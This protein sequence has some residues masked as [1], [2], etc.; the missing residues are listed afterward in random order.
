[1]EL[2]LNKNRPLV[3]H[4]DLN[5]CFATAAQQAFVHLRGKPLVV[6]AYA[7]PNGCVLSPSVEAKTYGIKTGMTVREAK[8]LCHHVQVRTP[9][10]PLV[11]DIH[12]KFK[13]IFSDY[14]PSVIPK[15]IDEAV[16]D[17]TP[18]QNILK[19]DLLEIG[20]EIKIRL[21]QEVGEWIRAS[22]GIGTNRFWAKTGASFKKPDG[23]E[24]VDHARIRSIYEKL[25]LVDL[26]GINVRLEARLN[27]YNIFTP[28]Q[29]LAAPLFVLQKQVFQ[30]IAGYYW[31]LRLRG[32][33]ID[34]AE[35]GRKSFGQDYALGKKTSDPFEISQIIMKL[36]EKMGRR[37][38]KH[39]L[40]S[41]GIHLALL[42]L[43]GTF[44]HRARK[45]DRSISTTSDIYK[46]L[47][48]LF[49]QS[50]KG[51]TVVKISV[52]CYELSENRQLQIGL[53]EEEIDKSKAVSVASDSINDRFGEFTIIPALMMDMDKV[54]LD[55]I[56]FGSVKE[57]EDLY[58]H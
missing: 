8:L 2:P 21:K 22:V 1:M 44:W 17:F 31:F 57:L 58:A 49:N 48:I 42:Y 4:I 11:R 16:I 47:I 30:S 51:K 24:L 28:L 3:M 18:V 36:S 45:I 33:E 25:K 14:S 19:R 43:D 41:R 9:D 46:R 37:L 32:Y 50:Q 12:V 29:F 34:A 39:G 56:A 10:P 38:R 5:S 54:V 13:K 15:S 23:L 26:H 52:T 27:A 20:T 6:A 40:S 55:R 35:F 53:F 7:T